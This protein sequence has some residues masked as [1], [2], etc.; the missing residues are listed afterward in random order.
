MITLDLNK[1]LLDLDSKPVEG[2]TIGV[3]L[4]QQLISS[5]KG[6]ALQFLDWAITLKQG[7]ALQL[8]TSNQKTLEDFIK[9]LETLTNLGK[10]RILQEILAAAK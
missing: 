3:L 1:P 7:K 8:D 9:S 10:G 2:V 4:A 6:D 5:P